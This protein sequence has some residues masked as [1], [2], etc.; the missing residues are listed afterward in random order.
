MHRI[1]KLCG[2]PSED[3]WLKLRSPHS[4]V[5]KPPHHYRRCVAETFQEYPPAAVRLIETL[6]SLDP[7]LRGTA[8]NALNSEV[9]YCMLTVNAAIYPM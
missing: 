2:S 9:C 4:T 5:F 8:A 7:A 1:F 6:L 3:Y